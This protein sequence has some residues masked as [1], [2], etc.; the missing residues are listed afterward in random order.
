MNI[1]LG[2]SELVEN[3]DISKIYYNIFVF[4]NKNEKRNCL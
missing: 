1:K 3:K 2:I 4:Y